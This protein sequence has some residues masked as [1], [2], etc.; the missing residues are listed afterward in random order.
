MP[1]QASSSQGL[2][3]PGL[4]SLC[5]TRLRPRMRIGAA[6]GTG[7]GLGPVTCHWPPR[8]IS[9]EGV[10][11]KGHGSA[12]PS[13][14]RG[15]S[16]LQPGGSAIVLLLVAQVE[17]PQFPLPYTARLVGACGAAGTRGLGRFGALTA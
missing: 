1:G 9:R 2:Q 10:G 4:P 17:L 14:D 11:P 8:P 12:W 15:T 7:K 5:H 3:P 6:E 13:W 16:A